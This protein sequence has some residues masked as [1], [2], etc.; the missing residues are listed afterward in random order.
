MRDRDRKCRRWGAHLAAAMMIASGPLA[1]PSRGAEPSWPRATADAASLSAE[2]AK[3]VAQLKRTTARVLFETYRDKNWE[4]F[5][6][7]AD[8]S[9]PV[10]LTKTPDVDELYPHGSPDGA[11]ICFVADEGTGKARSR[12]VYYMNADGTGRTLVATNAREPC[13]SPDGR[14]IAY[15]NG[16]YDRYTIKDY[17][18]KGLVI[19]DLKTGK[20]R[21]HPN[22]KLHHLYNICW[23]PC[24]KWF[25]STVHGGMGYKHA[26]LAIEAD[27]TKVFNLK[28]INGCRPDFSPDGKRVAWNPNDHALGM[29][30]VDLTSSAPK[31]T[32]VRYPVTCDKTHEV[33]HVDWSPSGKYLAF[34]YGPKGGEQMGQVA[35]GWQIGVVDAEQK[36]LCVILTTG[37][38]SNKE[39]DW[40]P[41]RGG[42][43]K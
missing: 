19:Y 4:L 16:E 42:E 32:N 5:V 43:G 31:V 41:A 15:L 22:K 2:Q 20:H 36:N 40:L 29:A 13:W 28:P 6:V 30:E 1:A 7:N 25:I 27:G 26:I 34:S 18:T 37:G 23:S 9:N 39:A 33:Y 38:L 8:G 10:N 24:G 21:P 35:K 11:R 14:A 17:A 12:N 3:L